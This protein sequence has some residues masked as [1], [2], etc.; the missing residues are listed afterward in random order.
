MNIEDVKKVIIDTTTKYEKTTLIKCRPNF[1][2]DSELELEIGELT[3]NLDLDL[4]IKEQEN[5]ESLEE[6]LLQKLKETPDTAVDLFM[7]NYLLVKHSIMPLIRVPFEEEEGRL[8]PLRYTSPIEGTYLFFVI[9][10]EGVLLFI[11]QDIL[12]SWDMSEKELKQQAFTNLTHL[13]HKSG[14]EKLRYRGQEFWSNEVID[15]FAATRLLA[16]NYKKIKKKVEGD[17][18]VGVPSR[19]VLVISN[20]KDIKLHHLELEVKD[21]YESS[22]YKISPKLFLWDGKTFTPYSTL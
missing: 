8:M 2:S 7:D 16:L 5:L 1:V 17:V 13:Y 4:L 22:E 20:S 15:G 21:I 6:F 18:I 19:D 10:N 3:L 11:D 9:N 14:L 12:D